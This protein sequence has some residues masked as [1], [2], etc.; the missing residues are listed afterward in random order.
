MFSD[1]LLRRDKFRVL[2]VWVYFSRET[3]LELLDSAGFWV[4]SGLSLPAQADHDAR[5]ASWPLGWEGASNN[6]NK[7]RDVAGGGS[8]EP[9]L[10]RGGFLR[11]CGFVLLV[12]LGDERDEVSTSSEQRQAL[13]HKLRRRNRLSPQHRDCHVLLRNAQTSRVAGLS[14]VWGRQ[15]LKPSRPSGP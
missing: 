8:F 14:R 7:T 12:V 4:D 2:G 3:S 9:Q 6:K 10:G 1:Q 15:C 13:T 5:L 11:R